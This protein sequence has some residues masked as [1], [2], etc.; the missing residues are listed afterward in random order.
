MDYQPAV[1][2]H[3][4]VRMTAAPDNREHGGRTEQGKDGNGHAQDRKTRPSKR[5][6]R[7]VGL[8]ER[9]TLLRLRP[10]A[11]LGGEWCCRDHGAPT[12]RRPV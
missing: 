2:Q 8:H 4:M 6:T 12:R 9:A 3:F 10:A 11:W 5:V 7:R 1:Q